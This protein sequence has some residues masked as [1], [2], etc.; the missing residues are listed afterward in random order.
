MQKTISLLAATAT[1]QGIVTFTEKSSRF[2]QYD[3]SFQAKSVK[4][5][6]THHAASKPG[7]HMNLI[8]RSMYRR[9]MYGLK[10]YQ[11]EMIAGM[12][13]ASIERVVQDHKKTTKVLQILKAK[14]YF[15]SNHPAE[16]KLISDI[17]RFGY[18]RSGKTF[19]PL[20]SKLSDFMGELPRGMTLNKLGITTDEVVEELIK[21]GLLPQNFLQ[22]TPEKLELS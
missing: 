17:F 16:T 11:P 9:L 8:Q 6:Q 1:S 22:L 10:E 18:A 15:E 3:Q 14:R 12:S 19:K 5:N 21:T 20:G 7:M 2:Q 4:H 13:P